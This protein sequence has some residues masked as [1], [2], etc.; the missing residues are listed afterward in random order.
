MNF[1]KNILIFL[2]LK[3]EMS[4]TTIKLGTFVQGDP[5]SVANLEIPKE[6]D[7]CIKHRL[8][9][10]NA[11]QKLINYPFETESNKDAKDKLIEKLIEIEEKCGCI[12]NI[13]LIKK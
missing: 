1:Y 4:K 11:I 3:I 2:I 6:K 12:P 8:E 10:L 13:D 7:E 5:L 9:I